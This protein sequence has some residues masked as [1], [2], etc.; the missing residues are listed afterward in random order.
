MTT[1]VSE[2]IN[3]LRHE[4]TKENIDSSNGFGNVNAYINHEVVPHFHK[5]LYHDTTN[6]YPRRLD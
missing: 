6:D 4:M 1:G 2:K 5:V 3:E